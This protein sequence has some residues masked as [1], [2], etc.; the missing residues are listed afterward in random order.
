MAK[1]LIAGCGD[2]GSGVAEQLVSQG[3]QVVG[4]RRQ[5]Q[6]FPQGVEGI[7]A[8]LLSLDPSC[9]PDVQVIFLIM[10][11]QG[12]TE[13]AYRLAYLETAKVLVRRYQDQAGSKPQVL[14][15]SSTSVY[16]QSDGAWVDESSPVMPLSSTAKVLVETEQFLADALPS[17][18]VRCSG[19][20]G[21]GRFRMLD[22]VQSAVDWSH[23]SWTNRVHRD[24]VVT[25]LSLLAQRALQGASLPPHVIITDQT[26]VS[27]WEVKLWLATQL[28]VRPAVS[29]IEHFTPSSGKR[30]Y[31]QYLLSQGWQPQYPSYVSGYQQILHDYLTLHP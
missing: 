17:V 27:M 24:D 23:N 28:G 22:K 4:I 31:A 10:T 18:A 5:G 20:Y 3:H 12:R 16:G 7:T 29:E 21:P 6:E 25:G 14:F 19:I 9:L 11:P 13:Q 15:V 2:L 30:I 26:P 1:V 8:D